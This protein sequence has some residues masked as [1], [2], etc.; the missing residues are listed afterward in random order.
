MFKRE[1]NKCVTTLILTIASSIVLSL[2][3]TVE[4]YRCVS[5]QSFTPIRNVL[6]N[7]S[8]CSVSISWQYMV[9]FTLHLFTD[10]KSIYS[11]LLK[12][13]KMWIYCIYTS[14]G[15]L[16]FR[17]G[18]SEFLN[19]F[20]FQLSSLF[21][22][23]L[24]GYSH[25]RGTYN[26]VRWPNWGTVY[27]LR[28]LKTSG[29]ETSRSNLNMLASTTV[30]AAYRPKLVLLAPPAGGGDK[31]SLKCHRCESPDWSLFPRDLADTLSGTPGMSPA[32]N[33]RAYSNWSLATYPFFSSS[34]V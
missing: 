19:I 13:F 8:S 4:T 32:C 23:Y 28:W 34:K 26:I 29:F 12:I 11:L 10:E 6:S 7:N 27:N 18:F 5:G 15:H 2:Y 31:V 25:S 30:I 14:A 9:C 20:E 33:Y 1:T 21:L 22:P 24:C 3:C 16:H 17:S